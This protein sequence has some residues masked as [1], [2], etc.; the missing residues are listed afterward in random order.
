MLD[1]LELL[2]SKVQEVQTGLARLRGGAEI[3]PARRPE[4]ASLLEDLVDLGYQAD[5]YEICEDLLA[6]FGLAT[7]DEVLSHVRGQPV[8]LNAHH[9]CSGAFALFCQ[10]MLSHMDTLRRLRTREHERFFHFLTETGDP[11]FQGHGRTGL[12]A[13]ELCEGRLET[14]LERFTFAEA[15]FAACGKGVLALKARVRRISVLRLL[16]RYEDAERECLEL[17]ARARVAGVQAVSPLMY[18]LALAGSNSAECGRV[19]EA[20]RR[21]HECAKLARILPPSASTA[22]A[23]LQY[24]NALSKTGRHAE[25]LRW[26]EGAERIQR[27]EDLVGHAATLFKLGQSYRMAGLLSEARAA[28]TRAMESRMANVDPEDL[29]DMSLEAMQIFLESFQLDSAVRVVALVEEFGR[30]KHLDVEPLL[31]KLHQEI[32]MW[33][34]RWRLAGVVGPEGSGRRLFVDFRRRM[35]HL[36]LPENTCE[37]RL[38]KHAGTWNCLSSFLEGVRV[39]QADFRR[40]SLLE[41]EAPLVSRRIRFQRLRRSLAPLLSAN[42]VRCDP[43]DEG[44]LLL[45]EGLECF[46]CN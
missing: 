43:D 16:L 15:E 23:M 40:E 38:R 5:V 44:R 25:A 8:R 4:V 17:V 7:S 3:S 35:V 27:T 33:K 18:S 39:G 28:I 19:R 45:A 9:M 6:G 34:A 29:Q 31:E 10:T 24:G 12:G 42:I 41:E 14:A 30:E 46:V 21:L 1:F 2:K 32:Q 26:L 11:F 36:V 22:F 20:L 13:I 37:L